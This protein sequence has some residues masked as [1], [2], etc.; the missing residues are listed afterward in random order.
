MKTTPRKEKLNINKRISPNSE[1]GFRL[2]VMGIGGIFANINYKQ[3][4]G[5]VKL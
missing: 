1:C 4:Y 2:D 3:Q 5:I